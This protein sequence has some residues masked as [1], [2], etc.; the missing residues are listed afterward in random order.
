MAQ[1]DVR[2]RIGTRGSPLAL[3]QAREVRARI[4]AAHGWPEEAVELVVI[5]TSGDMIQD[6][7]LAQAGGKGLFTKEIDAAM[8]AGEIHLAVHSAKDLPTFFPEGVTIAGYLPRED[9]RDA[10]ISAGARSIEDLPRN[11]VVGTASLRRGALVKRLR[12]DVSTTLLRGNVETRLRKT[13]EG[14]IHA[15]LLALA[16]LKRLGLADRAAA[17]LDLDA[18]PPAV[19]QGAIAVTAR[20]GDAAALEAFAAVSCAE[21]AVALSA[22]R[23]FLAVLDGS[24]KTPIAGHA[25]VEGGMVRFRGMLLREDGSETFEAARVGAVADAAGLGAEAAHDIIGRAPADILARDAGP[26]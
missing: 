3:W 14:E 18:F 24:C 22:E 5:K 10:L 2:L 7:A 8:L 25:V 23:A 11:A 26:R 1:G 6:R 21:T 4:L 20:G 16:G 12:P 17:V 13:Q 19:G 15:T 9:V